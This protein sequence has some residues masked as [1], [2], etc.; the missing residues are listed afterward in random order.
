MSAAWQSEHIWQQ[1]SAVGTL[2]QTINLADLSLPLLRHCC[3]SACAQPA[4]QSCLPAA[5]RVR[6]HATAL[7]LRGVL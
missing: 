4:M 5:S 2:P 6:G 7:L 1:M 3:V